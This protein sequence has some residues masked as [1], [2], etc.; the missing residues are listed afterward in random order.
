[1]K[2]APLHPTYNKTEFLF[3][4]F[5]VECQKEKRIPLKSLVAPNGSVF[6]FVIF[7]HDINN[8]LCP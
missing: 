3:S 1:M 4:L 8:W 2:S 5:N 6:I 7:L